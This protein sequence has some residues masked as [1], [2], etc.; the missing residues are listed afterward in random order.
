MIAVRSVICGFMCAAVLLAIAFTAG[1]GDG[2]PKR[3]RVSG[4]ITANGQPIPAGVI[5]F[6]PDIMQGN[7]GPQGF[8]SIKDGVYDTSETGR[9]AVGGPHIARVQGFDGKP[10]EELPL[11][12]MIYGEHEFRVDLPKEP[13]TKDFDLPPVQLTQ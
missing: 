10:G 5:F 4:K 2:G 7:D 1:C 3:Y 13:F 8:A 6:D 11:G 9:G 12:R